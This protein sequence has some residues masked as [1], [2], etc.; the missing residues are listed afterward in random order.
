MKIVLATR[1]KNKMCEFEALLAEHIEGIELL[2][3]DDVG[4]VGETPETGTTFEENAMIKARAAA[5]ESGY[6]S[7][8]DDSGLVVPALGGE[9]G[10]RSARYAGCEGSPAERDRANNALL[11]KN[12]AGIKDR[13]AEFVCCIACAYPKGGGEGDFVVTG[14]VS[15]E[16]LCEPRGSG[17]FGYDPLFWYDELGKTFAELSPEEKNK[18]S[19]RA[20]AVMA[21]AEKLK[22]IKRIRELLC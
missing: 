4:I 12:M 15:G 16:I 7:I 1:N 22:E 19:H 2:S 10:V 14:R 6:L 20:V 3:L 5:A 21:L 13:Y 8:A 17:G 9:P 18:V 11:L